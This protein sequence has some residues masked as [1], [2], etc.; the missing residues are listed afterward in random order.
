M[1]IHTNTD[2]SG[3]LSNYNYNVVV[4]DVHGFRASS[5]VAGTVTVTPMIY[6]YKQTTRVSIMNSSN[7][8]ELLGDTGGDDVAKFWF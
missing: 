7:A 3:S 6:F 5:A 8:I 1:V 2:L 4:K